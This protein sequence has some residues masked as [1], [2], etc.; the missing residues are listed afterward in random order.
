MA[1]GRS[2]RRHLDRGVRV[3]VRG[4][5]RIFAVVRRRCAAGGNGMSPGAIL[6]CGATWNA[7]VRDATLPCGRNATAPVP[8]AIVQGATDRTSAVIARNG[9]PTG[10]RRWTANVNVKV[11]VS[12]KATGK[13]RAKATGSGAGT[14]NAR[15]R[16]PVFD[17]TDACGR[18]ALRA[19]LS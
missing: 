19:V 9:V 12:A 16:G 14:G 11:A 2:A 8:L 1:Q 13:V 4:P 7:I 15:R 17:E 5:G 10:R 3:S 6:P 18:S